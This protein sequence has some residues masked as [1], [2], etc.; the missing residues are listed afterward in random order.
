MR[1][2]FEVVR[3]TLDV[4][5]AGLSLRDGVQKFGGRTRAPMRTSVSTS[6]GPG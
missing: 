6:W 2:Q 3:Y 4:L 5:E 1:L